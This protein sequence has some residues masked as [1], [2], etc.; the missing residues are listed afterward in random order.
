MGDP[1]ALVVIRIL[2][3]HLNFFLIFVYG[4]LSMQEYREAFNPW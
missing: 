4:D 1:E 2:S 3:F